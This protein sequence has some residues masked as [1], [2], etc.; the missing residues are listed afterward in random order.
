MGLVEGTSRNLIVHPDVTGTLTLTLKQV[1]L[2]EVL[3][4]VR[5]VYGYDYRRTGGAYIVLPATLQNR[6]FEIDYLNLIR[7][8]MSRTRVSSGQ[9]T[10]TSGDSATNA[11]GGAVSSDFNSGSD[12]GEAQTTGSVIDTVSNSDFW[13]ELQ[14]HADG[15]HGQRARAPDRRQC[16]VGRRVRARHARGAARHRRL[17]RSASMARRSGKSCSKPRSSRSRSATAFRPA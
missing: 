17:P 10:Q 1:T 16:A 15:D 5:D 11:G 9:V 12:D 7:G 2:P 3:D 6:V 14:Q 8:G 13:A 4:T